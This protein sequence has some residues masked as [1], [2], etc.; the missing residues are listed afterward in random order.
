MVLFGSAATGSFDPGIS[1]LDVLAE[2][3]PMPPARRADSYFGLL[4]E[5]EQLFGVAIDLIEPGPIRNPY[6][7]QAVEATRVVL[8]EAA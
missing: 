2:F 4:A 5:L 6:F 3:E 1:D 7:R 8:F